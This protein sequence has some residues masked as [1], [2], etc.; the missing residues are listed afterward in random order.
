MAR[1]NYSQTEK[2]SILAQ[3]ERNGGDI[4]T[5]AAQVGVPERTLYTWRRQH[6][7]ESQRRQ[8]LPPPS[9][10]PDIGNDL[11]AL[12]YL[13]RKIMDELLSIA[14]SFE[15]STNVPPAQRMSL[16]SGLLD[17]LMKLDSHL[18][19]YQPQPPQRLIFGWYAGLYI[20]SHDGYRGP[21]AP[22]ELHPQWKERYGQ[23]SRLEIFWGDDT[24]T[25]VPDGLLSDVQDFMEDPIPLVEDELDEE[26]YE[27]RYGH[28]VGTI[29]GTNELRFL[30]RG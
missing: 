14:S 21:F 30:E 5:T 18:K 3:L 20:R 12:A 2:V 22:S 24:F 25:V 19:P 26:G 1:R 17:R 28:R 4:I 6:Y 27:I 7:A 23:D 16:L 8:P 9:P 13:R 11:E 10:M 15:G 29:P